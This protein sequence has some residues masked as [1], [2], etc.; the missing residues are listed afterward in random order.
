[1]KINDDYYPKIKYAQS[2]ESVLCL[3]VLI[4]GGIL[5]EDATIEDG[6]NKYD[7]MRE[8]EKCPMNNKCFAL[9]VNQ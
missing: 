4:A 5:P 8:C 6:E 7:E 9:I 1:M 2:L 3:T